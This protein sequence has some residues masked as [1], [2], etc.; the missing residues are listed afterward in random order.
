MSQ[1]QTAPRSQLS[2]AAW[3]RRHPM[4]ALVL[5]V[6]FFEW[7][8]LIPA[9]AEER[10]IS[11]IHVPAILELIAGW[12]PGLAAAIVTAAVAGKVGVKN[13]FRRYLIWRVSIG[14]YLIAILGTA[15]FILGGIALN[16]LL[17][18]KVPTLPAVGMTPA[19]VVLVFLVTVA[20]GFLTN[21]EDVAWRGVA[22]P[23]LQGRHGALIASLIIGVLE[24]LTHLPYF[25]VYGDFRQQVGI[26]FMVFTLAIVIIM[27]WMYNSTGGS[28]LIVVLY[29]ATQN[30][31]A[32]L[33]DT[34]PAPGPNDLRPFI[35]A[36]VLMWV[37]ATTVII[38][39]GPE[40]L[41]RRSASE[42]P[43]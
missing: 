4:L 26:W 39:C 10:G 1:V 27:T 36:V 12:G 8:V 34:T 37:V 14:W 41:S 5:L 40:R 13:L 25:F 33:L 22:L 35:F 42:M 11:P 18:G 6:F 20:F 15:A 17:G 30:A 43:T 38:V 2:P 23:T 21:T 16:V 28:L 3:I 9:A 24:G 19:N 29:H 7:I 32:N 31:W